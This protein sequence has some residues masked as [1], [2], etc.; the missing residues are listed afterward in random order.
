[1]DL[2]AHQ[3]KHVFGQRP[4]VVTQPIEGKDGCLEFQLVGDAE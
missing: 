4:R 2:V 1:M 3:L